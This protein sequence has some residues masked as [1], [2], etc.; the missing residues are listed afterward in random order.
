M[1]SVI[2]TNIGNLHEKLSVTIEQKD[3]LPK[4]NAALKAYSKNASIPGFRKGNVPTGMVKKMAGASLYSDEILRV[5]GA[6]VEKYLTENKLQFFAR[7]LPV[8]GVNT[9]RFDMNAPQDY[10][11]DFE[12][13]LYPTFTIPA[14]ANKQ[15][16]EA[17]Q[18]IVT[19]EM[20][21]EE[22]EKVQYRA[23]KMND[24]EVIGNEDDVINVTFI[25]TLSG[26]EEEAKKTNSLLVKYFSADGQKM[27][28]GKKVGESTTLTVAEA[29]DEKIA[30]AILKDL[31]LDPSD[32]ASKNI[33]YNMV[34]DK[35]AHVD[36]AV[37]DAG[38]FAD[39][40]PGKDIGTVEEFKEQIKA[41]IQVY[42]DGQGRNKLH[43]DMYETLV[44]ET[45]IELPVAFLK[46]YIAEGGE[47]LKT[48][49]EVEKEWGGFE[50]G[51]RWQ[52]IS[53]K[54]F[55]DN[56]LTITREE[57]ETEMKKTIAQYFSHMGMGQLQEEPEWMAGLVDKQMKDKKALDE[58][59]NKIMADKIFTV[60]EQNFTINMKQVSLDQFVN[61]PS[62]H[63]HHH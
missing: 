3:Y 42:W 54:I 27:V 15:N 36:K 4:F 43:N 37:L 2:Q 1:A 41:E 24:I 39:M 20:V 19:D 53:E 12:L 32:A 35:I 62:A 14:I 11:F 5:A 7:P 58:A 59:Q 33:A 55:K 6:E 31:G 17:L 34:I 61:A 45:P 52:L 9:Y 56:N 49:D 28:M 50:H 23:G 60:L 21:A 29:F 46:K 30:P 26:N 51:L 63:H 57:L 8:V 47:S 18:V 10:V 38:L 40:Y 25:P 16:I 44:H 22:L 48:A 13:G